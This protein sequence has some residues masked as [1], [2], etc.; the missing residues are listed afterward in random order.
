MQAVAEEARKLC[1]ALAPH[2]LSLVAGFGYP[3]H[4]IAA[5]IASDWIEYN[6]YDNQGE[7]GNRSF[8]Q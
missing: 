8:L 4:I 1:S 7:L 3:D 5:P 6:K 2:S